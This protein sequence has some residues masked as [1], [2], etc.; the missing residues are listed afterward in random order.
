MSLSLNVRTTPQA[1]LQQRLIERKLTDSEINQMS[2]MAM[3]G[4]S[5]E[6]QTYEEVRAAGRTV[7]LS[8]QLA[9]TCIG[10][11][12][13]ATPAERLHCNTTASASR[14]AVKRQ[15]RC[16]S[17]QVIGQTQDLIDL[18]RI[19][20]RSETKLGDQAQQNMT[21]YAPCSPLLC[22]ALPHHRC[23]QQ[24]NTRAE[25][26]YMLGRKLPGDSC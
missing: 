4:V 18:Q 5:A 10:S 9:A 26:H 13:L 16:V 24:V 19:L 22:N 12:W 8:K 17:A 20:R 7:P 23:V 21:R 2:I 3:S 6:A 25:L 14:P 15:P 1:S 11:A